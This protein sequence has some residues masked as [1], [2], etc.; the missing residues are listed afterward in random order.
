[1]FIVQSDK[2]YNS[3]KFSFFG[4]IF[5]KK[6]ITSVRSNKIFNINEII[7]TCI[8]KEFI[9]D[10]YFPDLEEYTKIYNLYFYSKNIIKVK[11]ASI[12]YN[13]YDIVYRFL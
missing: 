10:S 11:D 7:I 9:C 1:M 2:L 13:V 4:S 6:S 12:N 3:F 8:E 5:L